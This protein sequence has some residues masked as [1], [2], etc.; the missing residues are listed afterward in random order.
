MNE[1]ALQIIAIED[2]IVISYALVMVRETRDLIPVFIP[3]FNT[4]DQINFEGKRLSSH[5]FYA[6][7]QVCIASSHRGK[8]I[9]RTLY[10]KH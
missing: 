3:M 7:G 2:N 8:G 9:F 6:M 4:F 10:Q 1:K 5:R